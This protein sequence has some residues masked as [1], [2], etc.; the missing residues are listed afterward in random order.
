[1]RANNSLF[2]K[3]RHYIYCEVLTAEVLSVSDANSVN[4]GWREKLQ[5]LKG[6]SGAEKSSV[7]GSTGN[8]TLSAVSPVLP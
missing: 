7:S 4:A 2:F 1:M 3:R 5:R 8:R 6:G